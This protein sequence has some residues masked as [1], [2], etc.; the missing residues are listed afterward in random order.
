MKKRILSLLL[1]VCMIAAVLPFNALA[2]GELGTLD[3][4]WVSKDVSVFRDGNTLHVYGTG[5]TGAMEDYAGKTEPGWY[6]ISGE[7]DT[8]VVESSV[9]RLGS[10]A[11]ASC[12]SLTNVRLKRDMTVSGGAIQLGDNVFPANYNLALELS[13]KGYMADFDDNQPWANLQTHIVSVTIAEGV[14]SIGKQAFANCIN[15]TNVVIPGSAEFIGQ[16]AFANCIRLTDVTLRHDFGGNESSGIPF[17]IGVNAFPVNNAGFKI[18]ME[19]TGTAAVPSYSDPSKQPWANLRDY[20]KTLVIGGNVAGI[21]DNAFSACKKIGNV[22]MYFYENG[23]VAEKKLGIDWFREHDTNAVINV[24]AS[25]ENGRAF[26]LWDGATFANDKSENTIYFYN[27]N[28]LTIRANWSEVAYGIT[29][30]PKDNYN[31]GNAAP[32]YKAFAPYEVT[33]KNSGNAASGQLHV[34]LSGGNTSAFTLSKNYIGSLPVKGTDTFTVTPVLGKDN[35]DYVTEVVVSDENGTIASFQVAFTV[36]TAASRA[37]D[38]VKRLYIYALGRSED[39]IDDEG[40]DNWVSALASGKQSAAQVAASFYTSEEFR[41]RG[42]SDTEFV[43]SLYRTLLNRAPDT[44]GLNAWVGAIAGGKT[45]SFVFEQFC[46]SA[47][48]KNLM[49]VFGLVPGTIKPEAYDMSNKITPGGDALN[50]V[51]RL[52]NIVLGRPSDAAGLENWTVQLMSQKMS[53]AQVAAGFFG[54]VEYTNLKKSNRD[55]VTDLYKTMLNRA[56]DEGGLNSWMGHL[57]AGKSRSWVF[58]QFCESPEFKSLCAT[59]GL[60]AGT[61]DDTKYNMGA[62]GT[63]EADVAKADPVAAEN[64]IKA[65]YQHLLGRTASEADLECWKPKMVDGSMTAAVVA[66]N[67]AASEECLNRK[68]SNTDYVKLLY[69]GLLNREGSETEIQN[70]VKSI[71]GGSKRNVVFKAFIDSTEYKTRCNTLGLTP[72]TINAA[73]YNMG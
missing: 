55:F 44:A 1:A 71:E 3:N 27:R 23:A 6:K 12:G 30:K 19:I 69:R 11:F 4:P 60:T 49:N 46:E 41:T 50:F 2:A 5:S 63:G 34:E 42:V 35:G 17:T 43:S 15:L 10:N 20:I 14:K 65:L 72:G 68:L 24:V 48:F 37:S 18:A 70:W 7:I 40:F 28:A 56:P 58:R 39:K 53:C 51:E 25:S 73:N 33:V 8:I 9:Q 22:T 59:Y 47:E 66:A 62:N 26:R 36:G 54:S 38:F 52:Y 32:G 21:G 57:A 16:E 45:R 31:F 13:G 64:F 29:V 61:I 67:V